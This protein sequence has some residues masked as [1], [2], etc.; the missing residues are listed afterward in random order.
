MGTWSGATHHH[1]QT[2]ARETSQLHARTRVRKMSDYVPA[3]QR[4]LEP[5]TA[6]ECVSFQDWNR[7]HTCF[8]TRFYNNE[9]VRACLLRMYF[10]IMQDG[11]TEIVCIHKHVHM[12]KT[13][14]HTYLSVWLHLHT[15]THTYIRSIFTHILFEGYIPVSVRPSTQHER[16]QP[17]GAELVT[18]AS[19][20]E[21]CA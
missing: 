16:Y 21:L 5:G 14:F 3:R 13:C 11:N 7:I 17:E 12:L 6:A 2:F 15:H 19:A 10:I 20:E 4:V 1:S 9:P 8:D 18:L